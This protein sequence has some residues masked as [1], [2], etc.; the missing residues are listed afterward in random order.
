MDVGRLRVLR[1]LADRGSVTAVAA[2][3]SFTPSAISQQLRALTAEVGVP[4]TE[5]AGRGLR[6]TAAGQALVTQAE[7]VFTAL[8]RAQAAVDGLRSLPSGE[9]RMALFPSGC[10]DAAGRPAAADDG[11][12][13]R[14]PAV[15][16]R[17][18]D[19]T[20]RPRAGRRL[21]RGRHPPRRA[22]RPGPGAAVH[23]GAAAARAARRR[24]AA[25]AP[26][27]PA[28]PAAAARAGR[29]AVDQRG[30]RLAGRRR[31]AGDRGAD[32]D[33]PAH[34]PADQR[35]L[36][37]RG[38]GGGRRGHRPAAPLLDRRPRRAAPGPPPG[39]R[40]AG[41]AASSRRCCAR[42]PRSVRRSGRCWT[43]CAPRPTP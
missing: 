1:E 37:H 6:L 32:R 14:R 15:P 21:R 25:G 42:A 11:V 4:L 24:A 5:P 40:G 35:L 17:R 41:R 9:V 36:R 16:R 2:A 31:A 26:A 22:H 38:A 12:S 7:E 10:P 8:A 34:R 3:L 33:E 20:G 28:P 39:G 27:R 30:R 29:R 13:G 18:H 23:R 19:P 43:R